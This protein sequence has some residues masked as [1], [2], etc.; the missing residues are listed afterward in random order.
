MICDVHA[1][2]IPKQFGDFMWARCTQAAGVEKLVSGSDYPVLQDYE[3]DTE[4]FAFIA[5]PGLPPGHA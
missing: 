4:T 5:R 1:H 2:Y 3:S